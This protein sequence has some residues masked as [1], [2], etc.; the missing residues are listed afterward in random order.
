[1]FGEQLMREI[2]PLFA[3]QKPD[4]DEVV[5]IPHVDEDQM[6]EVDRIAVE[7]FGLGILQMMENAG[8]NLSA[9]ALEML[10]T[11]STAQV[12]VA[13]GSGGNGGGGLCAARHLRNRGIQVSVVLTRSAEDLRGPAA[14]QL[15]ILRSAG[16]QLVPS[17]GADGLFEGADLILDALIG[18]SLRGAPS[19]TTASL[20][21]QINASR[22]PVIS[23][24]LPSGVDATSGETP[25]VYVRPR[26]T[27]T[28]ALPKPGLLN[29]DAG[30]L[31]LADIGIPP[32]VY[33]PLGIQADPFWGKY[34]RLPLQRLTN[35]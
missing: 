30:D 4:S 31:L 33:Q 7:E 16:V 18:Y 12:I 6:R 32:E 21:D 14:V 3:V 26:K 20:I 24:D 9:A 13:A 10:S 1:M 8:R 2:S 17:S 23:L 29:M 35:L 28:L 34:Y 5:P 27:L 19:G 11:K 15:N 22:C 25:G